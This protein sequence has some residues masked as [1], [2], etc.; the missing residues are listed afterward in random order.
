MKLWSVM[1]IASIILSKFELSAYLM[2]L[3]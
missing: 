3:G 2:F 1:I